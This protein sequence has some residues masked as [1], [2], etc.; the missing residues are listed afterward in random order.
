MQTQA[1]LPNNPFASPGTEPAPMDVDT[2]HTCKE[3]M[4]WMHG[5]CFGCRSTV[6]AKRDGNHDRDPCTY[7][8]CIGHRELVCMDKF[9]GKPKGQKAA[10]TMKGKEGEMELEPEEI[11]EMLEVEET[12]SVSAMTTMLAQLVEH[13]KVLAE[14]I[15][16]LRN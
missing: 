16:A 7:C 4:R 14:Q 13:Q 12:V 11:S 3:F 6:H 2:T 5:K 15:A 8:K 9:L 10:A 1:P